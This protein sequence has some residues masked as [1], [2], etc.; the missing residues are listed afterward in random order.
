MALIPD[1]LNDAE[2]K[3]F[4]LEF[5]EYQKKLAVQRETWAKENPEQVRPQTW[6][7][8]NLLWVKSK[9]KNKLFQ[10]KAKAG[11]DDW[12]N[13][14]TDQEKELQQIFQGQS[15][16]REILTDLHKKMDEVVGRQDR[17]LSILGVL[18]VAMHMIFNVPSFLIL[19]LYIQI[20]KI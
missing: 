17:S 4:E 9:R 5:E 11:E 13:W 6:F 14:F 19:S 7:P 20:S 10:A 8:N 1:N 2:S 12:E 15:Q 3:K 18:Q 16:I